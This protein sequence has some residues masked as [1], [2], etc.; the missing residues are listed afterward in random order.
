M[1]D[2]KKAGNGPLDPSQ[3]MGLNSGKIFGHFGQSV[4]SRTDFGCYVGIYALNSFLMS[5]RPEIGMEFGS[6]KMNR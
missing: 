4:K 3:N 6:T 2:M 1:L 5:R